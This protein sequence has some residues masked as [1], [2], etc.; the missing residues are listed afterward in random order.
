MEIKLKTKVVKGGNGYMVRVPKTYI[1]DGNLS[2]EQEYEVVLRSN[3]GMR[4]LSHNLAL[5]GSV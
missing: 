1:D 2:L 5:N 3:V 4:I